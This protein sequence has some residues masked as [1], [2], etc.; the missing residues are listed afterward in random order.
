M[1]WRA[2]RYGLTHAARAA[3]V[4]AI[5]ATDSAGV[6]RADPLFPVAN[7]VDDR[8]GMLFKFTT[9]GPA[10]RID[11]DLG[12][13]TLPIL[14]R[15]YI[16]LGHNLTGTIDVQNDDNASFSS[17]ATVLSGYAVS[18]ATVVDAEISPVIQRYYRLLF[19][20][21]GKWELSE[22]YYTR[23]LTSLELATGPEQGWDDDLIEHVL[24]LEKESGA[25]AHFQQGPDQRRWRFTFPGVSLQAD[26]DVLESLYALGTHRVFLFDPPYDTEPAVLATIANRR[27]QNETRVPAGGAKTMRYEFEVL[28]SL[29]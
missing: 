2:P 8:A 5:S 9:S 27:R 24:H 7:L 25:A 17:P 15:L 3:G 26:L 6:N 23:T 19:N 1:A 22:L 14:N 13:G 16:P 18:A 10:H 21:T 11:L 28:Q 20:G 4:A 29:A 12:T